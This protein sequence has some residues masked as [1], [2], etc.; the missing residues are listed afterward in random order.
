MLFSIAARDRV[1]KDLW[2]A[3]EYIKNEKRREGVRRWYTVKKVSDFPVPGRDVVS[4]TLL[5]CGG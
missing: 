3:G 2:Q 1:K 4:Q 5:E